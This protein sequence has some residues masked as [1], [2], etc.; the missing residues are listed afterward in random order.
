MI[1]EFNLQDFSRRM[2]G[3]IN[4]LKGE[5]SG[6]RTGRASASLLDPVVVEVYGSKMPLNQLATVSI[7]DPRTLSVQVWDKSQ[8]EAIDKAIREAGLGL[9]P[10]MDGQLIR[11]PI[12]E[13]NL[14]RR[15]ELCKVASKYAENARI[16]VRNVR[17]DGM[18]T[19]KKLEK[20]SDISKDDQKNYGNDIQNI[21]DSAI[22]EID[23]TLQKKTAE[24]MNV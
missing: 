14:E 2:D 1:D 7:P 23:E 8:A 20:S 12:P 21:T 6:L 9:N 16:A 24:I 5:F 17:R 22:K 10:N 19:L 13:L 18:D 4:S 3:A 11:I 15:E